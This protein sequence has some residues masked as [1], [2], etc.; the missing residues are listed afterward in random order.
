VNQDRQPP[1]APSRLRTSDRPFLVC[2]VGLAAVYLLVILALIVADATFT[3]PG[4]LLAALDSREIR[5]SLRLSIVTSIVSALLSVA[6]AV[7]IGYLFSRH[8][9]AGRNLLE[10][11]LDIPIVLPP[12]VIGLSLL[13]LFRTPPGRAIE[14]ACERIF[15]VGVIYEIPAIVLAQFVVV[16]AFAVRTMRVAFDQIDPRREHVALTLGCNRRQAFFQVAV[17]EAWRGVISAATLAWARAIGEFGPV[18]VFAGVT[19]MKT[20]VLPTSIYLEF[21]QGNIEAAVAVSLIMVT[22][23]VLV[24]VVARAAGLGREAL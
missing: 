19:R 4:E 18:L 2:L 22:V 9:F 16:C 3:S 10:A 20:E 21:T 7:P 14:Q 1:R 23:A 6:F 24:L 17:P 15:G 13:I 11:I 5:Y 12:L 8:R